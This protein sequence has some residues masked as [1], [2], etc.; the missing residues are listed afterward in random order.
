M[1]E[2]LGFVWVVYYLESSTTRTLL[3]AFTT[4]QAADAYC[5]KMN[6]RT[7]EGVRYFAYRLPLTT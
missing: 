4:G 2:A 6:S 1:N 7:A 3:R 5:E